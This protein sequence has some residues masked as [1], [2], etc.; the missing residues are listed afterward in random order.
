[1]N[2]KSATIQARVNNRIVTAL[3]DS[4]SDCY[5][6]V[7]ESLVRR[8]RKPLVDTRQ[9]RLNSFAEETGNLATKRVAVMDLELGGT[10]RGFTPTW[11]PG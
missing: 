3:V 9:R 1:M 8:L 10:S 7:D 6:V 4:G 2:S 5:A 11:S